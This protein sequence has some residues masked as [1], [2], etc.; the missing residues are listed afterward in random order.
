VQAFKNSTGPID[1][2]SCGEVF[3]AA[4]VSSS[5]DDE[6]EED[7]AVPTAAAAAD[8]NDDDSNNTVA[9]ATQE[10]KR[11]LMV[12]AKHHTTLQMRSALNML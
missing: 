5:E 11:S 1:V 9:A 6:E 12:N 4:A 7:D 8:D 3:S 10:C 2:T